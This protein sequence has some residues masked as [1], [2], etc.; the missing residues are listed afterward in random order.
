MVDEKNEKKINYF[1][2]LIF[3][4]VL[5]LFVVVR[6]CAHYNLFSFLGECGAFLLSFVT[7][8]GII[9]LLPVFLLKIFSKSKSKEVFSYCGYRKVSVKVVILSVALGAVVFFLN[10]YISNFFQTIIAMFG[11]KHNSGGSSAIGLT[12]WGLLLNLFCTAVLPAI[13]EETLCRGIVLNGNAMLGL[14]KSVLISGLLFGLLHLNIE[15]F[16]YA[17]LIG[18]LLGYLFW[19]CGSIVPGMIVHFMNNAISV[20]LHFF[21]KK[22][23]AIGNIFSSISDFVVKNNMLGLL[24]LMLVLILLGYFAFYLVRKMFEETFKASFVKNEKAFAKYAI[25]QTYFKQI[26]NIKNTGESGDLS[27]EINA[28][29]NN[30]IE[31]YTD[32]NFEKLIEQA[33]KFSVYP[34]T[35]KMDPRAKIFLIGSI[36]LSAIVTIL[37]FIWGLL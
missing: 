21:E 3:F 26:E 16:F 30:A 11:Y 8:V 4:V 10:V 17:T 25:R 1:T 23:W 35:I 36:V 28:L 7:Q 15:Q 13:C 29:D 32:S 27:R 2:N 31:K 24:V 9:F 20:L 6:I 18:F 5:V 19:G 37:T 22:G 34:K 14:K 12:W 33:S